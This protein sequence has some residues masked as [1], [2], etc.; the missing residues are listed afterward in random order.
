MGVE[1][2][3]LQTF[4][5]RCKKGKRLD[6][7]QQESDIRFMSK[8]GS[9]PVLG[10]GDTLESEKSNRNSCSCLSRND[11][12]LDK[13]DGSEGFFLFLFSSF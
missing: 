12:V 13:P 5:S 3:L 6:D 10:M 8:E 1:C 2:T 11:G 7:F 4:H 9:P